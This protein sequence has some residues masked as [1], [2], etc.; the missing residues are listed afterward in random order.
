[1]GLS[2]HFWTLAGSLVRGQ[3]PWTPWETRLQDPVSG[4]VRLTGR[5]SRVAGARSIVIVVHGLG[6]T[7]HTPYANRAATACLEAGASCLR[8]ALRGADLEGTDFYHAGLTRDLVAAMESP[9]VAAHDRVHVLGYSLGGHVTLRLAAE[10]CGVSLRSVAAICP[11]L[12]LAT[13]SEA[14]DEAVAWAYRKYVLDSLK[15]LYA[16]IARRAPVPT[17]VERIRRV[18]GLR[19]WDLLTVVPRHG[20]AGVAEYHAS[21]SAGPRLEHLRVP[22]LIVAADDD[23]VV[24]ERTVAPWLA[25]ELPLLTV[26]WSRGGGHVSLPWRLDLGE[27][28]RRGV[29]PQA[30]SWLLAR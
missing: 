15:R 8:L 25:D 21:Q 10:D 11:P 13:S 2:G 4:E 14:F 5:L 17:P 19:E 18:R 6:G 23:P 27:G 3:P 26:H 1:M 7:P 28:T 9:E 29:E 22:A 30:V 20:F 16:E 24:L 12:D